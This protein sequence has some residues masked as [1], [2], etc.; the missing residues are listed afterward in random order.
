VRAAFAGN[1]L[2]PAALAL[3]VARRLMA[4]ELDRGG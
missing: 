3:P 4:R 1:R 2:A